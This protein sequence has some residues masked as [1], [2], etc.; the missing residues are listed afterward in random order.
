[1]DQRG[2]AWTSEEENRMIAL[3]AQ[4]Q[5][6]S[7]DCDIIFANMLGRTPNAIYMRRVLIAQRMIKTGHSV[8]YVATLLHLNERDFI[9][10]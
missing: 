6:S 10:P 5:I 2:S 9:K 8:S 1:M 4:T 3:L 7:A